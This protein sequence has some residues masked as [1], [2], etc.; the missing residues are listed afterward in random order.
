M[1]SRLIA[2]LVP[3]TTAS[4]GLPPRL[5]VALAKWVSAAPPVRA[6]STGAAGRDASGTKLKSTPPVLLT[7]ST[8]PLALALKPLP[9]IAAASALAMP[10]AVCVAP[11][12]KVYR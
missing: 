1:P 3:S 9:L 4:P 11:A 7:V 6:A 10:A 2:A 12:V 5:K 8:A